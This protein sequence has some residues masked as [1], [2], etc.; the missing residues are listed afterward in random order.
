MPD[1]TLNK[2]T[3]LNKLTLL[4]PNVECPTGKAYIVWTDR[5]MISSRVIAFRDLILERMNGDANKLWGNMF[6]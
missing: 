1:V 4:L 2:L 5:K 3:Q 6:I